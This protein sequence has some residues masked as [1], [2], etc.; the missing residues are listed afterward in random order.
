MNR[1]IVLH[2]MFN[3]KY[4]GIIRRII[5]LLEIHLGESY[6]AERKTY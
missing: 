5:C 2:K 1:F 3:N 6:H 4:N